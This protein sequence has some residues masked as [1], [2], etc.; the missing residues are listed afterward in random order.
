MEI[1]AW[2]LRRNVFDEYILHVGNTDFCEAEN[3]EKVWFSRKVLSTGSNPAEPLL[4]HKR[5]S[6]GWC[7]SLLREPLPSV[8]WTPWSLA[9]LLVLNPASSRNFASSLCELGHVIEVLFTGRNVYLRAKLF[10]RPWIATNNKIK[11]YR[12]FQSASPFDLLCCGDNKAGAGESVQFLPWD[13]CDS[14]LACWVFRTNAV[15]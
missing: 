6:S 10:S 4:A 9:C 14:P 13:L 8:Q 7:V 2:K 5:G 3:P 11:S 12:T 15:Q 1:R